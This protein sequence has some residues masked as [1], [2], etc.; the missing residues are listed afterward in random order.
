[1][2]S[3]A[4]MFDQIQ[5]LRNETNRHFDRVSPEMGRV[6]WNIYTSCKTHKEFRQ[7]AKESLGW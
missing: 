4:G 7:K 3:K 5:L 2:L 6:L 1:M